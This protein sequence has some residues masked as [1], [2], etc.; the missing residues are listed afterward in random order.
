MNNKEIIEG[1]K[2]HLSKD[3]EI[4]VPYLQ[5]ELEIYRSM[6][7]EEVVYAIA[8]L[9]FQYMDP[10]IKEKLDLKLIPSIVIVVSISTGIA[11]LNSLPI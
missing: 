11:K 7:N 1:I 4:D 3:R 8:N 6:N 2:S 9:L 5:T 10:S